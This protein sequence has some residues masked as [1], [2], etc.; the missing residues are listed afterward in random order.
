MSNST[1]RLLPASHCVCCE[2]TL[3]E[4]GGSRITAQKTRG[5]TILKKPR[6]GSKNDPEY[7]NIQIK[8][9]SLYLC[10]WGE[11]WHSEAIQRAIDTIT[12]GLMPWFC[13]ACGKRLCSSCGYPFNLAMGSDIL[14]NDGSNP[15]CGIFP[16]NS[17]CSNSKCNKFKKW[18]I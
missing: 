14:K 6:K 4:I 7:Q 10:V 8:G 5:Y 18:N 2:R 9:T 17:G 15:H 11:I 1:K 13:Q 16:V 3:E 12:V